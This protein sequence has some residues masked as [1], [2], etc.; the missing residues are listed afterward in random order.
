MLISNEWEYNIQQQRAARFN[1]A[2]KKA[3]VLNDR[4]KLFL[5]DIE[6]DRKLNRS[7]KDKI[8]EA[9]NN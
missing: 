9:L 1:A 8:K 2:M 6:K 3:K 7:D 4:K 5:Q